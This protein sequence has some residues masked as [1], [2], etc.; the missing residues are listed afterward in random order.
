MMI[1]PTVSL[2]I[3]TWVTGYNSTDRAATVAGFLL[4]ATAIIC[5]SPTHS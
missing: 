1:T 5:G 3:Q 4:K 2:K